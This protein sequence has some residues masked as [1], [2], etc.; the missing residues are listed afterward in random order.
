MFGIFQSQK[1]AIAEDNR[2]DETSAR[3]DLAKVLIEAA[4]QA[5]Q[6]RRRKFLETVIRRSL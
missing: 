2:S 6:T 3:D 1:N 4:P 5:E